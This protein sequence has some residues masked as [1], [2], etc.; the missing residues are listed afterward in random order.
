MRHVPGIADARIQEPARNPA[1][2]VAFNRELAG[3]VGLT[4]QDAST[5]I[6]TTL[7]GSTQ[8]APT[9][10]FDPANGVSYPVSVQTP[11]Y[12]ID[13]LGDLKNLPLV[14]ADSTQLLGGLADIKPEPLSSVI[15]HYDVRNTVQYLRD[16]PGSRPRRRHRRRAEARRCPRTASCPRAR[17]CRS[18]AR[19]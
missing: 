13:T 4:E 16:Q 11:Q 19:R 5:N 10:W 7:S 8:T 9:Y 3:V 18:A 1:L 2:A 15:D 17:R 14:A 12:S 6:Q